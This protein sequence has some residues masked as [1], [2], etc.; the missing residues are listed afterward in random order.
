MPTT[1]ANEKGLFSSPL[2]CHIDGK[3]FDVLTKASSADAESNAWLSRLLAIAPRDV[4]LG[5][6]FIRHRGGSA[7]LFMQNLPG[8][9]SNETTQWDMSS[10]ELIARWRDVA[11]LIAQWP[12]VS[13]RLCTLPGAE[14]HVKSLGECLPKKAILD[15]IKN[16]VLKD[17]EPGWEADGGA[18]WAIW[19]GSP[20]ELGY[21]DDKKRPA[22]AA[23][24]RLFESPAAAERT[25][26]AAKFGSDR[27]PA[28]I[29]RL[30]VECIAIESSDPGASCEAPR[31]KM[32]QREA[33]ELIDSLEEASLDDIRRALG[34]QVVSDRSSLAQPPATGSLAGREEGFACWVDRTSSHSLDA[35]KSGFVNIRSGLGPLTGAVLTSSAKASAQKSGYWAGETSVV[36]VA[37]WPEAIE[38]V[39]GEPNRISIDAAIA[40][41]SE[42]A[43][44]AALSRQNADTLKARANALRSGEAAPR[45]RARSL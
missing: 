8:G 35:R 25:A 7:P 22:G 12:G 36:K 4:Q 19:M 17:L 28:A 20:R 31:R 2:H 33:Q 26:K 1:V 44:Q 5:S 40:W 37:C 42:Q 41:E 27:G 16:C 11:E 43:A 24:A 15:R 14:A 18:A 39:I 9:F 32:A 45:K 30:R 38:S 29:V 13:K 34:E 6:S 10:S 21:M 3:S 23:S